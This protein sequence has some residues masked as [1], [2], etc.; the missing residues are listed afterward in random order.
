MRL[1]IRLIIVTV[2]ALIIVVEL[3]AIGNISRRYVNTE[4]SYMILKMN[5]TSLKLMYS[6]LMLNY[7]IIS[8]N[9]SALIGNFMNLTRQY[10]ILLTKYNLSVQMYNN[11]S[12]KY[13][14]C[15]NATNILNAKIINY[16]NIINNMY[17]NITELNNKV[18]SLSNSLNICNTTLTILTS[19]YKNKT[20]ALLNYTEALY[21]NYTILSMKYNSLDTNYTKLAIL[22]KEYNNTVLTLNNTVNY[23][24]SG[25]YIYEYGL[26]N[27]ESLCNVSV[28]SNGNGLGVVEVTIKA[29]VNVTNQ[30]LGY[31]NPIMLIINIPVAQGNPILVTLGSVRL[32]NGFIVLTSNI[33]VNNYGK[34]GVELV[35]SI[36]IIDSLT[37]TD[38]VIL[39]GKPYYV[40]TVTVTSYDSSKPFALNL[41]Y[42]LQNQNAASALCIIRVNGNG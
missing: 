37:V 39:P 23:L 25:G 18:N 21:R 35:N 31:G 15:V 34:G 16:T 22:L 10:N 13:S 3:L 28:V 11:I 41:L 2:L 42:S 38:T 33:T 32:R 24:A 9:F 19:N 20:D 1:N 14:E 29:S 26:T 40:G 4:N 27:L 36:N 17:I 6:R 12:T 7:S 5:Y 8:A 30:I